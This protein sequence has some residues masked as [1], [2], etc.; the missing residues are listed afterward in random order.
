MK[1]NLENLDTH[2]NIVKSLITTKATDHY[3]YMY[4]DFKN[5]FLDTIIVYTIIVYTMQNEM[6]VRGNLIYVRIFII[7]NGGKT[8]IYIKNSVLR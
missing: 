7:I 8:D 5:N 6:T 2:S 3:L 4:F 1:L